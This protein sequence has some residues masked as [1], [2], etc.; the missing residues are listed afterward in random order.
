VVDTLEARLECEY[1]DIP[2]AV[3]EASIR[4]V[5]VTEHPSRPSSPRPVNTE[6]DV[7]VGVNAGGDQVGSSRRSGLPPMS[8]THVT[9]GGIA[10]SYGYFKFMP[11]MI[12]VTPLLVGRR[13]I[14]TWKEV[15]EPQLEMAGLMGFAAGTVA[16]PSEHYPDMARG[17][18]DASADGRPGDNDRLLQLGMTTSCHDEDVWRAT[19]HGVVRHPCPEGAPEQLISYILRDKAMQ[20]G[21]QTLEL[22]LQAN[23]VASAKQGGRP[24]QRGQSSGGG[25][26][27]S[28]PAKDA[29]KKKSAKDSGR[30]GGSRRRE[31]AE[32]GWL[33]VARRAS[34]PRKEKQST[35]PSTSAKDADSSAGG[36]GREDKEA[37]CSLV[38]V[39]EP[40]V[41][42]AP[43]AGEDFQAMA[44]A[45]HANPTVV[46]LDS[47]CSHHLMGTKEVFVDLQPSGDVKHVRGFNEALQDVQGWGT[48]ALQGEAGKQVLI[49]DVLYV[50]G[51]HANL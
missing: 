47:G 30:G 38:G 3:I 12:S 49:P 6:G 16:T 32:G 10:P 18:D 25:S 11:D 4:A 29:D 23:Y 19:L 24:G 40:T 45:V 42:L 44:T 28:R 17:A 5:W 36:K 34:T 33:G 7:D 20:E 41:S 43:E 27:G 26:S 50:P 21:E 1:R 14:L 35:E 13:D 9:A 48:V 39:V 37:S 51:V 8:A 2:W 15:I 31:V 22:L 46:L